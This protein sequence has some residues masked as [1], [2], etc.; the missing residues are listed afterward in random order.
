MDGYRDLYRA[1][2]SAGYFT[3]PRYQ[4]AGYGLDGRS[5]YTLSAADPL[6]PAFARVPLDAFA[7]YS[8][9]LSYQPELLPV[10]RYSAPVLSLSPRRRPS[11]RRRQPRRP[12]PAQNLAPKKTPFKKTQKRSTVENS[13]PKKGQ[14]SQRKPLEKEQK[15]GGKPQKSLTASLAKETQELHS[16]FRTGVDPSTG[17]KVVNKKSDETPVK[18]SNPNV[19]GQKRKADAQK[20]DEAPFS[21]KKSRGKKKKHA[22][23]LFAKEKKEDIKTDEK[24]V[25][26]TPKAVKV[27]PPTLT[28]EQ[29]KE[30]EAL[31]ALQNAACKAVGEFLG[32]PEKREEPE[33]S[34]APDA[35]ATEAKLDEAQPNPDAEAQAKSDE[36]PKPA[37][38]TPEEEKELEEKGY[39]FFSKILEENQDL[40]NMYLEKKDAGTFEC[41]ICHSIDPTT[42]KKFTNLTS[43]VMH[44]S[45]R[46]QKLPEHRGYGQAVCDVLGWESPRVHKQPA[47]KVKEEGDLD[48]QTEAEKAPEEKKP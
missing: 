16:L 20:K 23:K 10:P 19:S 39:K 40:R 4:P 17:K 43:L 13:T 45:M 34:E 37:P 29:K 7:G 6:L 44:T 32:V 3:S 5:S 46:K 14:V 2:V 15:V 33:K 26:S 41:L 1:P 42:S 38:L 35:S 12:P 18:K 31:L 27:E 11:P 48:K 22:K 9:P 47:K 36:V 21:T 25:V 8:A 30:V 24:P 28:E